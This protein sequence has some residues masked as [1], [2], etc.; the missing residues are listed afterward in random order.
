MTSPLDRVTPGARAVYMAYQRYM[1]EYLCCP[2]QRDVAGLL[3]VSMDTVGR[4]LRELA[5]AGCIERAKGS[6]RA[7][8][9]LVKP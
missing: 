6:Q 7:V 1:N 8:T 2:T 5:A 9:L 4:R 3:G